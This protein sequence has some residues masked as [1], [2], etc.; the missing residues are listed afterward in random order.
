[1]TEPAK[2][3]WT[4]PSQTLDPGVV[5]VWTTAAVIATALVAALALAVAAAFA[6]AGIGGVAIGAVVIAVVVA[7]AGGSLAAVVPR[8]RFARFR[9]DVTDDGVVVRHGWLWEVLHI[10]PHNRIQAV[11]ARS[12]PIERGQG[13]AT[14]H[15]RTASATGSPRIPGLDRA[16]AELLAGEVARRA[17]TEDAT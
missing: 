11:D 6:V 12:G 5:R 2:T 14:L 8:R 15:L 10:V 16:A 3:I 7:V 1:V 4:P 13:L 9:W 17:G